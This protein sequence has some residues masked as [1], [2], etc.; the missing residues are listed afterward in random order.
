[1]FYLLHMNIL[2][3]FYMYYNHYQFY[4]N[5][6][7]EYMELIFLLLEFR[8]LEKNQQVAPPR[9]AGVSF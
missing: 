9:G 4:H 3:Y 6:S 7:V 1:M 8:L 5:L 2:Y